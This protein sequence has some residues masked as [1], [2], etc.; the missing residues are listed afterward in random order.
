V[1]AGAASLLFLQQHVY[2][3]LST[4]EPPR[5]VRFPETRGV[6]I[7]DPTPETP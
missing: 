3:Q 4:V 5:L 6:P 7:P 1:L 2:Y